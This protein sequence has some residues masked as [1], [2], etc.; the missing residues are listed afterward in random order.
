MYKCIECMAR[1]ECKTFSPSRIKHHVISKSWLRPWPPPTLAP[2]KLAHA[3]T[4]ASTVREPRK[5]S[6]IWL[7]TFPTVEMVARAH[8]VAMLAI[9]GHIVH[10]NFQDCAPRSCPGRRSP[11][12]QTSRPRWCRMPPR[13]PSKCCATLHHRRRHPL[14]PTTS[15][16]KLLLVVAPRW[17]WHT[18]SARTQRCSTCQTSS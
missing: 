13:V 10:L 8:D 2:N 12:L 1:K 17:W 3:S 16:Q 7:G 6:P 9:K 18:G 14:C 11:P 4:A 5:K 15:R